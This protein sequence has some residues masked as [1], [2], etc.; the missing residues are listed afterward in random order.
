MTNESVQMKVF[1]KE[2][3]PKKTKNMDTCLI[4]QSSADTDIIMEVD[5]YGK[6]IRLRNQSHE[7]KTMT[8]WKLKLQINNK[9]PLIYTFQSSSILK[10]GETFT[11]WIAGHGGAHS[12]T[13][14]VWFGLKPWNSK[15]TLQFT[16]ITNNREIPYDPVYVL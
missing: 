7:E 12:S 10:A 15:D 6:Y 8:G 1:N 4:S 5:K 16:L 2:E 3:E 11:L 9:K 13:E 14:Q